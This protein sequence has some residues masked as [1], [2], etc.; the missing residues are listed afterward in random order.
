MTLEMSRLERLRALG[1]REIDVRDSARKRWV[2]TVD[3]GTF[4][5]EILISGDGPLWFSLPTKTFYVHTA[6]EFR[7]EWG[8]EDLFIVNKIRSWLT[9]QWDG[10]FNWT[11]GGVRL[12]RTTTAADEERMLLDAALTW[13]K[14][15]AKER[16]QS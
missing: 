6:P 10:D 2:Y 8:P 13:A 5:D 15:S 1:V 9:G 3:I 4:G 16:D 7:W 11:G 14:K 12:P